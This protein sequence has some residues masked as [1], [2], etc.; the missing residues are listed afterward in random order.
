MATFEGRL[1]EVEKRTKVL[2]YWT[3]LVS[4]IWIL[5]VS[6]AHCGEKKPKEDIKVWLSPQLG[7]AGTT[8]IVHVLSFEPWL[9]CPELE[10]IWYTDAS[11]LRLRSVQESDCEPDEIP[12]SYARHIEAPRGYPPGRWVL[13]VT[14]KQGPKKR[15]YQL[16]LEI[17]G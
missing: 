3:L 10:I 6:N 9:T 14:L 17:I 16:P 8:P 15:V 11:G 13:T 4:S 7:Q 1:L 2:L 5:S 12:A